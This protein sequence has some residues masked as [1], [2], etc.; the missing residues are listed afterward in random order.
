[1]ETRTIKVSEF[2]NRPFFYSVMPKEIFTALENAFLHDQAEVEVNAVLF[3]KMAKDV[4]H[5]LK[6]AV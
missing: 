1:M 4:F 3:E 5:K 2:Y 6:E